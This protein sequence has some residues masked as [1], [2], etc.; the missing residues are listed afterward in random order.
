MREIKVLWFEDT[1]QWVNITI[2]SLNRK[3]A[4]NYCKIKERKVDNIDNFM[5]ELKN[6]SNKNKFSNYDIIVVDYNVSS[7]TKGSDII[8]VLSEYNIYGDILFYSEKD[9]KSIFNVLKNNVGR[10]GYENIYACERPLFEE[11]FCEIVEKILHRSNDLAFARGM[12]L[13][14]SANLEFLIQE[15]GINYFGILKEEDQNTLWTLI[16]EKLDKTQ[17][18]ISK[19]LKSMEKAYN[20]K[21]IKKILGSIFYILNSRQKKDILLAILAKAGIGIAQEEE[22]SNAFGNLVAKRNMLAHRKIKVSDCGNFLKIYNCLEDL[23]QDKCDCSNHNDKSKISKEEYDDIIE[24]NN[25]IEKVLDAFL[26]D[27]LKG[28]KVE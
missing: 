10:N 12:I 21:D 15:L 11:K 4:K 6:D 25:N 20:Q 5:F 18:D 28:S 16:K 3:L 26:N 8:N 14:Q 19:N 27:L 22:F 9:I 24:S 23:K 2:K 1:K 17:D 13:D 7:T